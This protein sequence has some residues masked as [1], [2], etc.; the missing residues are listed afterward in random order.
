MAAAAAAAEKEGRI[1]KIFMNTANE[2]NDNGI[3]A[4]K[5]Y[6]L[7]VPHTVVVDDYLPLTSWGS[8][9]FASPS[10]DGAMWGPIIEKAFAKYWGNYVH[11]VGGL[12][13]YATRTL[14]GSPWEEYSK[15]KVTTDDLWNRLVAV[16]AEHAMIS[17]GTPGSGN[18]DNTHANGLAHSHAYTVVGV[19]TLSTG[20]RLVKM[21]NPWGSERFT[22]KWGDSS[23]AWTDTLRAEVGAAEKN[24]GFFFMSIEDYHS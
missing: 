22:G 4:V 10:S 17:T 11:I 1:E 18:H 16:D 15:D 21:R 5:F 7:G 13:H 23:S 19:A 8:T 2:L 20:D 14:L 3:Y 12:P 9:M 24:D 6:A